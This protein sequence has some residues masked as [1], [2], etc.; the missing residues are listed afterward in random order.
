MDK[1][2]QN[3]INHNRQTG[4]ALITGLI[5]LVVLTLLG[6]SA[7][8][9]AIQ[10]E[11]ISRNNKDQNLAFQAAEAALRDAESCIRAAGDGSPGSVTVCGAVGAP[12]ATTTLRFAN[13]SFWKNNGT[14]Y[15]SITGNTAIAEVAEQP[16]YLISLLKQSNSGG[17]SLGGTQLWTYHYQISTIGFGQNPNTQRVIQ[18][19]FV[20]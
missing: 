7:S 6:F 9:A 10:Q 14:V 11:L 1:L 18:G 16:R 12:Y 20:F 13:Q 2:L 8:R 3:N 17:L 4:A 15:G 5:L 19:I